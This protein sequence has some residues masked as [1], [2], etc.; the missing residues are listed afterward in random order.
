MQND[1]CS[2]TRSTVTIRSK[3]WPTAHS[4]FYGYIRTSE[5]EK[6]PTNASSRLSPQLF[7]LAMTCTR[8]L[9]RY[10]TRLLRCFHQPVTHFRQ[11]QQDWAA[12]LRRHHEPPTTL[13]F[14]N[15]SIAHVKSIVT[16]VRRDEALIR[17][18]WDDCEACFEALC[19]KVSLRSPFMIMKPR[20]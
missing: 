3:P 19:S 17:Q 4:N 7:V 18:V 11:K 15:R 6:T 14:N 12:L 16:E 10:S 8:F 20:E 5:P 13:Q 1:W 9:S 2:S